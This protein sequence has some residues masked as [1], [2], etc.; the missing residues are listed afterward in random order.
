LCD[1]FVQGDK[2]GAAKSEAPTVSQSDEDKQHSKKDKK[3]STI[4]DTG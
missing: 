3:N 4:A 2:R 1:D